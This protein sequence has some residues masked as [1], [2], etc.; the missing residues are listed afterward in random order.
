MGGP[1]FFE[2]GSKPVAYTLE[3][4]GGGGGEHSFPF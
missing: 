4:E 1:S 3:E 2:V